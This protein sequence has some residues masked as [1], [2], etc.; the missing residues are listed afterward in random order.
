MSAFQVAVH[1]RGAVVSGLQTRDDAVIGRLA[2][3]K[4]D[5]NIVVA[6]DQRL[7]MVAT[8]LRLHIAA[9]RLSPASSQGVLHSHTVLV[10]SHRGHQGGVSA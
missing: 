8:N 6:L 9:E 4:D 10:R 5:A 3:G 2:S 7:R 1:L